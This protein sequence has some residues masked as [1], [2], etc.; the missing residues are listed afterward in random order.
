M[1]EGTWEEVWALRRSKAPLLGRVRGGGVENSRNLPEQVR[2]LRGWGASG[3]GYRWR[4]HLLQLRET[5]C[6]LCGLW[7]AGNL[8]CGLRAMGG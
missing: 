4:G 1:A 6:F 5:R 3:A 8:L 2:A 7:V